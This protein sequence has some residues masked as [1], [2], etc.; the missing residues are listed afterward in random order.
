MATLPQLHELGQSTWL[1]YLRRSFIQSGELRNHINNG[2][3]GITAN[4]AAFER[5]IKASTDYDQG[6]R[7]E[8]AK[9]TPARRIHESL[10]IYDVQIAADS[11][12]AVYEKSDGLDG[13]VSLELDPALSQDAVY[14]V[15]EVRHLEAR[16][17]R[18]NVLVEIPATPAGI[19]AVRELTKD[20]VSINITHVF[21]ISTY[22]KVAHA[23]INGVEEYLKS[24]S[25]WRISPTSVASISVSAIDSA[26]DQA[27]AAVGHPEYQ[28]QTA[29][30]LAKVLYGRFQQIFSGPRWDAIA[31]KGG[32]VLRPKWTRTTPRNFTYPDTYYAD[33]LIGQDTVTTFSP[34][35]LNAFLDHGTVANSLTDRVEDA[36]AHLTRLVDLNIDLGAGTEQLLRDYLI[37]SEKRFHSLNRT[38]S[39]KR[40]ELEREWKPIAT[41]LNAYQEPVDKTMNT[42]CQ[43]RVLCRIWNHDHTVW[44]PEP[45]EVNNRLGWLRV[46]DPM[47]ENIAH[48]QAFTHSVLADGYTHAL[49][50]GEHELSLAATLFQ[51]SFGKPAQPRFM[52]F[53]HLDLSVLTTP[54]LKPIAGV[55]ASLVF[56]KTL[57]I[58]ASKSGRHIEM[59]PGFNYFYSKAVQSFGA[60]K[61]G[62]HFVAITDP[63]SK[64]VELGSQYCFRKI[65]INDP[66]IGERYS[67]L[68]FFGLV[69]AALVGTDLTRLLER[70]A[71]MAAN[72]AP[73]HR[74]M[75]DDNMAAK[76]GTIMS[77]MAKHG[78]DK[79]TFI[80]SWAVASFGEWMAQLIAESSG[81]AGH[82]ILP[83]VG[84][85][86]MDPDDYGDDR[87]FVH[88]RLA[89]DRMFDTAVQSLIDAGQ[90]VIIL[91]LADL[92]DLGGQLFLWQMATAVAGHIL[93][94]NPFEQPLVEPAK[95]G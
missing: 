92:Y 19:E 88:L 46:M 51:N 39:Q 49:F 71:T 41:H 94:I 8:M 89:G 68:S 48:L 65:F 95:M 2:I 80:T 21:S 63:G 55:E 23:Y 56:D 22:E 77:E 12:H 83:V 67:A 87:L 10:M 34:A 33:A 78:R 6:I 91:H 85:A 36:Y 47:A 82:G 53:E 75:I 64:L 28:G 62:E 17:N 54:G 18:A 60:E 15:A 9:G 35:T 93:Q 13:F 43:D 11:L 74:A 29:I 50:I 61:A 70:A 45:D 69:P 4:A 81:K 30:A 86:L 72:T 37:A 84:E 25:V 42:L 58:V 59:L 16:L 1:N 20:G 38:M 66:T 90:P 44:H 32:R 3:Q 24:H 40:D 76:I 52:P 14:T 26:A 7:E 57:F 5:T 79:V 73:C 27:L 31:R